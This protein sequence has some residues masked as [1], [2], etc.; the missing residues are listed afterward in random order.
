MRFRF[1]VPARSLVAA[2]GAVAISAAAASPAPPVAPVKLID[3]DEVVY[4]RSQVEWS[5]AY[6]QWIATFARGNSPVSDTTGALCAAK[7]EGDVWFLAT[8]DGTGPV[9]RRCAIPAGK[10]LFVP[11]ANTLERSG[12]KE[13]VCETM[14]RIAA[15]NLT[16][17]T[18]LTMTIDGVAVDN[19]ESHRIRTG[20]CFSL[21]ARQTPRST[22]KTAVAD[23]YYVMLQ[24]L[25]SGPH[26]IVVGARFDS[27]SLST[28][29]HL[30]VQ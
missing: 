9:E 11:L 22:A 1:P 17:V 4:D 3:V 28:T 25:S 27:T 10:T 13:P 2:L 18:Q 30:D 21:G 26:T 16:H 29:Y 15:G 20:D 14:V 12:N 6:L 24:P 19:M 7:Q 8:S 23:G 5:E